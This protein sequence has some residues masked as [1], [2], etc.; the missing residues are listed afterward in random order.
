M[1]DTEAWVLPRPRMP[2][3]PGSFPLWFE[4][5]LI[6]LLDNP[7]R[8]LHL[9]GG[10]AEY[11]L[12]MDI[13]ADIEADLVGD[14]HHLP[15]RDEVF[16]LV[17]GD[18]PYSKEDSK[19][20]YGTGAINYRGWSDEAVRVCK[21][22]GLVVVYHIIVKP[23]PRGTVLHKRILMEVGHHHRVRWIGIFRKE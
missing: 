11:G 5:K 9:F 12:R 7:D 21:T 17:I 1:I 8:I 15:F 20:M 19:K 3:Y 2:Y 23:R 14:A 6:K 16:D 13:R 22:G 18:P 10:R 4:K